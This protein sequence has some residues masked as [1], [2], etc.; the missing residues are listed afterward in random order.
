LA[1]YEMVLHPPLIVLLSISAA[2]GQYE[3]DVEPSHFLACVYIS[4][5]SSGIGSWEGSA[6]SD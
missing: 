5:I 6:M 1:G 4:M 2:A 3:K